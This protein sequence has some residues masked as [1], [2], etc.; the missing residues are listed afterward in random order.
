MHADSLKL[1]KAARDYLGARSTSASA[2]RVF[3]GGRQLVSEFRHQLSS[4]KIRKCM[5]L[6]SWIDS[7]K[8]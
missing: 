6:R 5:L 3:S 2:E 8:Q 1:A 7:L 4:D